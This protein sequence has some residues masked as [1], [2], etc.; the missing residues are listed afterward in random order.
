M[1]FWR[2]ARVGAARE[3]GRRH[4]TVFWTLGTIG[5]AVRR[6]LRV[7]PFAVAAV[8]LVAG[9]YA[10][11]RWQEWW[12]AHLLLVAPLAAAVAAGVLV[13]AACRRFD[14]GLLVP[15]EH[16]AAVLVFGSVLLAAGATAVVV[17]VA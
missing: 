12:L 5:W 11:W 13:A 14:L 3:F 16:G 8:V 2:E 9:G 10:A 15:A 7:A 4:S 17:L 1:E 6:V